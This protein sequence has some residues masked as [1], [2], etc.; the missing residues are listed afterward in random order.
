M[1]GGYGYTNA[2]V[3]ESGT[4]IG[5]LGRRPSGLPLDNG[6]LAIKYSIP[7]FQG[8]SLTFGVK[9]IGLAYPNAAALDARR[10][11]VNPANTIFD[12]GV[13]YS[14]SAQP[15]SFRHSIRVSVKNLADEVYYNSNF[16]TMDRR[17]FF[18]S[19]TLNH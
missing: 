8:L 18:I 19:Y 4:D 3:T 15:D 7:A 17:G 16:N 14:W 1:L 10:N 5:A 11:V 13:A 6:G 2:R 12:F 9:Y